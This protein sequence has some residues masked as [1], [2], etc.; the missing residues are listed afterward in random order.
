[1]FASNNKSTRSEEFF[2]QLAPFLRA[3]FSDQNIIVQTPSAS[4]E[5]A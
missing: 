5:N 3:E 2:G 4:Q 1:M